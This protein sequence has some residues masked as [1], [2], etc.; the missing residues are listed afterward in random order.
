MEITFYGVRGSIP[1]P[2]PATVHYGG[3]TTC[4]AVR[5]NAGDIIILD[6]GSGIRQLGLD[7]LAELPVNCSV[8]IT[9]THW[10]HI[11]GLPFFTPLFIPG[12]KVD[13]Y[14]A[15][16]PVYMKDLKTILSQQMEYCYFPV[17]EN[18][19]KAELNYT[20][21]QEGQK[22][23]VGSATVTCILLNHPVL[24]FGY[25]VE[26]DG[27][28]FFFTGDN[29]PPVNIY[30]PEDPD[31]AEYQ[32][33]LEERQKHIFDF[34]RGIDLMVA[35]AQYTKDEYFNG[36]VGWGHGYYESCITMA[37]K[38]EVPRLYITHHDPTRT[39][40][41]LDRIYADLKGNGAFPEGTEVLMA[42]ET[43]KII[44]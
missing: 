14:G 21:L 7:L 20:T 39:D 34:F 32:E 3:N 31:F 35:D 30:Q 44:L 19:L 26:A 10:D 9:H 15:F 17:R 5:T 11:Q 36:K 22:I 37:H 2:G 1:S 33:L 41:Q 23:Q 6:G 8:F 24:N 12:N 16:D 42:R 43:V 4:I 38:A 18:E 40:E 13:F 28:R 29:E 25:L 27:K